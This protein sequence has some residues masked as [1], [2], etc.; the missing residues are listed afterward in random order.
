MKTILVTNDDGIYGPGLRPLMSE[1][2]KIAE[3]VAIVPDQERSGMSHSITI[4]RPL[5][6]KK[7]EKNIYVTTGTPVDCVRFAVLHLLR[8]K[9][10]MVI[11]GINSG[12]N[13]GEDVIY[14]GT[15]AGAREGAL[16]GIPSF[17]ISLS[18]VGNNNFKAAARFSRILAKFL[19]SVSLPQSVYLNINYPRINR[20]V[21]ITTLGKR[22]YDDNFDVRIDPRGEKYYWMSGKIIKSKLVRGT[23]IYSVEN[24]RVSITPLHIETTDT[25]IVEEIKKWEKLLK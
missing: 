23:D 21:S 8:S 20:G 7:L 15:V 14:S 25:S 19:F 17:A 1:L 9:V 16:L 11:S 18:E 24:N 2:K 4:H 22:N 12:P 6:V 3:V 13:L 5:W 10:D